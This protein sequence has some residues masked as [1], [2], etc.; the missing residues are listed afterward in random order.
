MTRSQSTTGNPK[1][2]Q[3]SDKDTASTAERII[4]ATQVLLSSRCLHAISI[5]DIA[6]AA[7]VNS[8]LI[9]YHF[10]NKENLYNTVVASL[11]QAYQQQ[12]VSAFTTEGDIRETIGTVCHRIASFHSSNPCMLILY[13]RELTNPSPAYKTII[14]PCIKEA[15]DK[16]VAMINAGIRAGVVC[17]TTNPRHVTLSLVGMVNY[18]FMTRQIMQDLSLEPANNVSEYIDFVIKTILSKIIAD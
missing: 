3:A 17:P 14:Q 1:H 9:S 10:K 5:R 6:S 16:C 4:T 13:F 12:V 15:S 11:F 7:N 2:R 18:F 8:A